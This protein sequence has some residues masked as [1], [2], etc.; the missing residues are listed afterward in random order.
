MSVDTPA[1][2]TSVGKDAYNTPAAI[3]RALAE[4]CMNPDRNDA[5]RWHPAL[6]SLLGWIETGPTRRDGDRSTA[7]GA[8]A[9]AGVLA[10]V[11]LT[12]LVA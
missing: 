1:R 4:F 7:I 5:Y 12:A 2:L 3:R 6:R 9:F 10:L 11:A 8:A